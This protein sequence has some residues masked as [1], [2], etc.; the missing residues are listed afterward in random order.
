MINQ[1]FRIGGIPEHFNFPWH[2]ALEEG[3]FFDANISIEWQDIPSGT[4]AMAQALKENKLDIAI[5]LTEGAV[6]AITDG[7]NIRIVQNYVLSPLVWGIHAHP[8][9]TGK[10]MDDFR[11]GQYAISRRGSGSHLMAHVDAR[12]RD[13]NVEASQFNIVGDITGAIKSIHNSETDLYFGEK[14]TMKPYVDKRE[15]TLIDICPSPW[16]CFVL[17]ARNEVLINQSKKIKTL[18]KIINQSCKNFMKEDFD[19]KSIASRYELEEEDAL[20]WYDSTKWATNNRINRSMLNEV[21]DTLY[22]LKLIEHKLKPKE[23][24]HEDFAHLS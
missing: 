15:L 13:W 16:S 3:S 7:L 11:G 20:K 22:D 21:T 23:M 24:C 18:Q 14:F 8:Q 5:M 4:G 1:T 12:N 17:V 2:I 19:T 9:H 6:R 10:E